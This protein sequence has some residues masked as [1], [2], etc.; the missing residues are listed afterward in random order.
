[1][2]DSFRLVITAYQKDLATTFKPSFMEDFASFEVVFLKLNLNLNMLCLIIQ[3]LRSRQEFMKE[4]SFSVAWLIECMHH[5]WMAVY[6]SFLFE[7]C[8]AKGTFL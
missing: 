2:L 6:W 3:C 1:M 8:L 7:N 5:L 4:L